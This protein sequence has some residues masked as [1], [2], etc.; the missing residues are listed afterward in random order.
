VAHL[1]VSAASYGNEEDTQHDVAHGDGGAVVDER[2]YMYPC[3]LDRVDDPRS[4][5]EEAVAASVRIAI[6]S[7]TG[8]ASVIEGVPCLPLEGTVLAVRWRSGRAWGWYG[9]AGIGV[10]RCL[11]IQ[12]RQ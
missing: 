9:D 6:S 5:E 4:N 7:S 12:W 2:Q 8:H 1:G 3:D 11:F 10:S